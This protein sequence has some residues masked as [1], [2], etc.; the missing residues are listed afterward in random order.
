MINTITLGSVTLGTYSS[1]YIIEKLKGFDF[2]EVNVDVSNR[3]QYHGARLNSYAYGERM[4][5]INAKIYGDTASE[6]ET[7][8]QALQK[9]LDIHSGEQTMTFATRGGLSLQAD[10]I[11]N[12]KFGVSYQKGSNM[13]SDVIIQLVSQYPFILSQTLNS[14]EVTPFSGG[15]FGIPFGIVFSMGVGGSGVATVTNDGNGRAYP[16]IT[17]QGPIENPSIQNTTTG[18]TFSF[19]YTLSTST[20]SIIVDTYNR[21]A[22]LNGAT[23]IK[24]YFSGDWLTLA[25]GD[26]SIKLSGSSTN[27][28]TKAT[29]S[30]RDHYL[31]I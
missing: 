10:V 9:A 31:G 1:G 8:R 29:F 7:R 21:T 11:A 15:G 14:E 25:S 23:N 12:A 2:P 6:F 3:G 5:T 24:Q 16:T 20:D 22:M 27:A 30:Y 18:E 26:N 13:W 4:Y 19:I 28:N 17:I